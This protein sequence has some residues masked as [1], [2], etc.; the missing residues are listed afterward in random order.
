MTTNTIE[1]PNFS[2]S[3]EVTPTNGLQVGNY[4]TISATGFL[5][6]A[7]AKGNGMA[8]KV[9]K[10]YTMPDGQP[11]VKLQCIKA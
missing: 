1:V 9:V 6:K 7:N 2:D 8:W 4:L 10:E 5:T 3:A 11:G